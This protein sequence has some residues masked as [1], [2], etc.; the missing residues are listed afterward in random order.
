MPSLQHI[1]KAGHLAV[2]AEFANRGYNVAIPE[3]DI[4]DDIFV[5]FSETENLC[6][7]DQIKTMLVMIGRHR[8]I[9]STWR[10]GCSAANAR[11]ITSLLSRKT[12]L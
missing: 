7:F 6:G 9:S 5:E 1:G 8:I 3:I 11:G 4:G 10:Q 12:W 2:M